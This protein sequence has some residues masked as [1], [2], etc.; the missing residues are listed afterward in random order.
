MV[1]GDISFPGYVLVI[2][3]L[4]T[5]KDANSPA[6]QLIEITPCIFQSAP[7]FLHQETLTR[8][9]TRCFRWRDFEEQTVEFGNTRDRAHPLTVGPERVQRGI[10]VIVAPIEPARGDLAQA[11]L[12]LQ[13]H[14]PKCLDIP[15]AGKSP[16]HSENRDGLI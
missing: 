2:P 6:I 9:Q 8:I 16:T 3:F 5:D 1:G 11:V 15:C 12:A 4:D 7:A 13:Q 10:T 14:V